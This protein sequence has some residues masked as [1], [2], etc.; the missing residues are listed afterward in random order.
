MREGQT[1]TKRFELL[2]G[3]VHG[4]PFWSWK[5]VELPF[6]CGMMTNNGQ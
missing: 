4:V 6:G 1:F 2:D 5:R 3:T